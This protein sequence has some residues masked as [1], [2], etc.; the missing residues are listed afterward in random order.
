MNW[1]IQSVAILEESQ[2][3]EPGIK[4]CGED[5]DLSSTYSTI[6]SSHVLL[7]RDERGSIHLCFLGFQVI[8]KVIGRDGNVSG[9]PARGFDR[10]VQRVRRIVEVQ[11]Q[12]V[13][14]MVVD[15]QV[16]FL[17][18]LGN[19]FLPMNQLLRYITDEV[20]VDSSGILS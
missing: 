1:N 6:T 11:D 13:V 14:R 20:D 19:F 4:G 8:D 7:I 5:L 15:M 3:P 2:P 9:V 10:V 16:P 12:I 17:A 18:D